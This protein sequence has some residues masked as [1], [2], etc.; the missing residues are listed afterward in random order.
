MKDQHIPPSAPASDQMTADLI[1]PHGAMPHDAS[2]VPIF[3]TSSFLFECYE[4]MAAAFAGESDRYIYTRGNNPTVAELEG[5]IAR[6]EGVEAARGFASGMA[7][8]AAAVMPFVQAGDRLVAVENLYSDA[9][10]LF[11]CV[12]KKFGVTTEYVDGTDTQAMIDALPGAKLVYLESPTSWSFTTQDLRAIGAAAREQ[13]VISVIDNSWATPLFQRP[14]EFGIDLI[15]HAASKYLAGH[16]DTIAGL[17]A[18]PKHLIG[19]INH[20]A[21]HYLGGKMSPF[22]AWLVLRGMR[23]LHLRMARHLQNGLALGRALSAHPAVTRVR[24]PAFE[25]NPGNAC[26]SGYGGLFAFDLDAGTDIARFTDALKVVKIGVSWGGPESLVIPAQ[27]ALGLPGAANV[28]QR[29][30]TPAGSVRIA[31]GLECG[32]AL[33]EDVLNAIEEGHK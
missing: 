23:T 19:R 21:Y 2:S 22:D 16:S 24:H 3:Q 1:A 11:E 18:G 4:D 25:A 20:E 27:A 32:D 30:G 26:L 10:R 33:V 14:A 12:L 31:A 13:G 6:M 5:L 17:V 29:F 9:F 28:F 7:A 15:V 8:I